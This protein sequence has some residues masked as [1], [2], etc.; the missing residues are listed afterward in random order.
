MIT[1]ENIINNHDQILALAKIASG[2]KHRNAKNY[3]NF[4]KRI[5]N[6]IAF[7]VI[8]QDNS[9]VAF[10]GIYNSPSWPSNHF[11]ILDRCFYFLEARCDNIAFINNKKLK[12]LASTYL[13]P[14]Q[15][16]IVLDKNCIPF[17][18]IQEITRRPAIIKQVNRYNELNNDYK[19]KVLDKMYW[20]CDG[21]LSNNKQCWQNVATLSSFSIDL[22]SI[23]IEQAKALLE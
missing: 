14:L 22:P 5:S 17:W 2:D 12:A 6:Y 11:R 16:K 19:F 8:N 18:S 15:T 13:I 9:P 7:H 3:N 10:A 20:T 23:N 4:E 1:I 21:R